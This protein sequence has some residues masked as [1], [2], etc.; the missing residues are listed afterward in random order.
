[1]LLLGP[2]KDDK[3]QMLD[4]ADTFCSLLLLLLAVVGGVQPAEETTAGQ[5]GQQLQMLR[6]N[7]ADGQTDGR[8]CL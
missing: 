8:N 4:V 3:R 2:G 6:K 1:M 7:H 5:Q